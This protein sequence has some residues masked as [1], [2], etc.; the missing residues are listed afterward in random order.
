MTYDWLEFTTSNWRSRFPE[1]ALGYRTWR[2]LG[3]P[4]SWDNLDLLGLPSLHDRGRRRDGQPRVFISHRQADRT[5]AENAARLATANG[6]NY[7]L[8]VHDPNLAAWNLQPDT[9][10]KSIAIA[11][12][13]EMALLNCS[14]VLAI[15]SGNTP[16]SAWVPYEYGRV[17]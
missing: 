12:I 9:P 8:D 15:V 10:Q 3:P 7:W 1:W 6:F 17:K 16:G 14:H 4:E 5:V 13:I 2:D 11:A